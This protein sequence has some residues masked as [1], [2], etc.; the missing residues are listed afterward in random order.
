MV[1]AHRFSWEMKH[2]AIPEGMQTDHL[3][4]T[5]NCVSPDHLEIVTPSEN[6]LRGDLPHRNRTHCRRCGSALERRPWDGKRFCRECQRASNRRYDAR[7]R[8]SKRLRDQNRRARERDRKAM[9]RAW[10]ERDLDA[11]QRDLDREGG[12]EK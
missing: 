12:E 1:L 7:T 2:G 4:R 6:T 9:E 8:E 5:R 3:C 11:I 10:N